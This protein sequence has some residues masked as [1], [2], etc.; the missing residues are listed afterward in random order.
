MASRTGNQCRSS[1]GGSTLVEYAL[2]LSLLAG[3]AVAALDAVTTPAVFSLQRQ[4]SCVSERPA[5]A[6]C[7]RPATVQP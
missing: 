7:D 4:A 6:G 1:D 5:P 3:G 2:V